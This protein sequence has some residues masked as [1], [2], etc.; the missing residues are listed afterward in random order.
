VLPLAVVSLVV[1]LVSGPVMLILSLV[2]MGLHMG[3]GATGA[4]IVLCL[5]A[6][7]MPVAGLYLAA[8]ALR[9]IDSRPEMGGRALATSGACAAVVG[10][11]WCVT[12][13]GLVIVKHAID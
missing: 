12:V 3:E 2:A 10:V 11:L 8:K 4:A 1:S 7:T 6:M 13:I 5:L 9:Q